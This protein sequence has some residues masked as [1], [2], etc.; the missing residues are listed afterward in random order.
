MPKHRRP[1]TPPASAPP[2]PP[3]SSER[4]PPPSSGQEP[5]PT[6]EASTAGGPQ[7]PLLNKILR[8]IVH[9]RLI[10]LAPEEAL[11][12]FLKPHEKYLA[13][14]GIF[15]EGTEMNHAWK[16]SLHRMLV[17]FDPDM[18]GDLQQ[19][20]I[21]IADVVNERAHDLSVDLARVRQIKLP[22]DGSTPSTPVDIIAYAFRLYLTN[23]KLFDDTVARQQ[24]TRM[25]RFAEF[26][27]RTNRPLLLDDFR[28]ERFR[29]HFSD[30]FADRNRTPFCDLHVVA[31]GQEVQFH[32]IHGR[33]PRSQIIIKNGEHRTR[34][35]F[36]PEKRDLLIYDHTSGRL[37]VSAQHPIEQEQYREYFGRIFFG[38]PGHF[39]DSVDITVA[40]L[41]DRGRA[42]LSAEGIPGLKRVQL[43]EISVRFRERPSLDITWRDSDLGELLDEDRMHDLL[44][45]GEVASLRFDFTLEGQKRI[46]KVLLLPPNKLIYDRR[47]GAFQAR[48]F[49]LRQGFMVLPQIEREITLQ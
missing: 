23:R 12:D 27:P 19:G 22:F 46:P 37:A 45:S 47:L 2:K 35:T 29:K 6:S 38:A 30:F 49:L 21:D 9:P 44:D 48:E 17:Q 16:A 1:Q 10:D 39:L 36:V 5:P 42:A 3:P 11:R 33:P 7:P 28:L 14:R 25:E 43:R 13:C 31:V 34:H 18:P 26:Y 32:V 15:L 40:P 41:R 24:A 20:F 8:D 4:E